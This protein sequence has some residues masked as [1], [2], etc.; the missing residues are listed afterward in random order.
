M[1][2]IVTNKLRL[3][4][5][6][7][8]VKSVD[9]A[10]YPGKLSDASFPFPTS[11]SGDPDTKYSN[12]SI[13]FFIGRVVPWDQAPDAKVG[14]SDSNPPT[15]KQT[16]SGVEYEP[17]RS[18]T[19]LKKIVADDVSIMIKRHDWVTGTVYSQYDDQSES[20]VNQSSTVNPYYVYSDSCVFM[21]LDN[22]GDSTS[23]VQP[24]RA[25]AVAGVIS[26]SFVTSDGYR[27]KL[28][29]QIIGTIPT[30]FI[31]TN[32]LPTRALSNTEVGAGAAPSDWTDLYTVQRGA[33]PGKLETIIVEPGKQG[34]GYR[35]KSSGGGLTQT[36]LTTTLLTA[37]TP[38]GSASDFNGLMIRISNSS[39]SHVAEVTDGPKAG[40]LDQI[41]FSPAISPGIGSATTGYNFSIGPRIGIAGDGSGAVAYSDVDAQGRVTNIRIDQ[42]GTGYSSVDVTVNATVGG[43]T[44]GVGAVTRAII[45]P[46]GG[47][48]SDPVKE[49]GG[50]YAGL[51]V[52]L[53]GTGIAN[54]L[55]IGS[56]YRQLGV[57]RNP[58]INS[59]TF[60][61]N[62]AAYRQMTNLILDTNAPPSWIT[63]GVRI[64]G[65]DSAATAV[66]VDVGKHSGDG[67]NA[68]D[69]RLR[70]VN[71][72][73]N[74]TGGTFGQDYGEK[75]NRMNT[76][77]SVTAEEA[78]LDSAAAAVNLK[79]T[80]ALKPNTGEI[81]YLE[82]RRPV[83]R[84]ADQSEKYKVVIEF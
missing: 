74:S 76:D 78:T 64:K 59:G 28:M 35:G 18:M 23:T 31:F 49:L 51:N 7:D 5:V 37:S 29:Y 81:L 55:P 77:G 73:T 6:R 75:I 60:I 3:R 72:T 56:S 47:Y 17:W 1:P 10:S 26:N 15:V 11:A 36:A 80:A 53:S 43:T 20:V 32:Y 83:T 62:S 13:Y 16:H 50:Y 68:A 40:N 42:G 63:P 67:L 38:L 14:F 2:A 12:T 22:V 57:I 8:F 4:N 33:I 65:A 27:W 19:S 41:L 52:T 9:V 54:T 44:A 21:C 45:P 34:S 46:E 82:N 24:T 61:A 58:T 79:E 39:F 84:V 71:L 66:V 69:S 25:A 30:S 48:G 70:V